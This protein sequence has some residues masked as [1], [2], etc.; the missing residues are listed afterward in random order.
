MAQAY[1]HITAGEG[2]VLSQHGNESQWPYIVELDNVG[3]D[4]WAVLFTVAAPGSRHP[5][6]RFNGLTVSGYRKD[7]LLNEKWWRIF[8][9][10]SPLSDQTLGIWRRSGR[11]AN[12][13]RPLHYSLNHFNDDGVLIDAALPVGSPKYEIDSATPRTG[14]YFIDTPDGADIQLKKVGGIDPS[15][16]GIDVNDAIIALNYEITIPQLSRGTIQS[17]MSFK[18]NTNQFDWPTAASG[19]GSDGYPAWSLIFSGMAFDDV[20][21]NLTGYGPIWYSIVNI[22]LLYR[23]IEKGVNPYGWRG[24]SRTDTYSDDKNYRSPVYKIQGGLLQK[25]NYVT[26]EEASFHSL[27]GLLGSG[28]VV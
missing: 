16:P 6:P 14:E 13:V 28:P 19:R 25:K 21:I 18:W 1:P 26:Y 10:Y 22:E 11:F 5:D 3:D 9:L 4:P 15:S 24:T 2:D 8:V 27:F 12:E 7:Q 20:I 23:P 17:L